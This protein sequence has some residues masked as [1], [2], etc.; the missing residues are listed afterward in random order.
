MSQTRNNSFNS[1]VYISGRQ[2]LVLVDEYDDGYPK[3]VEIISV[4]EGA[5]TGM[6]GESQKGLGLEA[7]APH[8]TNP[9][10]R[11][12][13]GSSTLDAMLV[14]RGIRSSTTSGEVKG[15]PNIHHASSPQ[16]YASAF[17][18][19][20]YFGL[21]SSRRDAVDSL[22]ELRDGDGVDM[23]TLRGYDENFFRS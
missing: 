23:T 17:V 14:W 7:S 18:L 11:H 12:R 5:E 8:K 16:A 2:V 15:N 9:I 3:S 21:I 22:R 4:P 13:D 1:E 19:M 6:E 20:E 10:T